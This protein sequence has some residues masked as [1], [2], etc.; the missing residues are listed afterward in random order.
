MSGYKNVKI[1]KKI[2]FDPKYLINNNLKVTGKK[3]IP[4]IVFIH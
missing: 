1:S 4:P 3:Q 2:D